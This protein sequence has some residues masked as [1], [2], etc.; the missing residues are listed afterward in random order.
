MEHGDTDFDLRPGRI[1]TV[2]AATLKRVRAVVRI[3]SGRNRKSAATARIAPRSGIRAHVFKGA[4]QRGGPARPVI[5]GQRR[6]VVKARFLAHGASKLAPL[7]AHLAYLA[8]EARAPIVE[9]AEGEHARSIDHLSR[10]AYDGASRYEF[11]DQNAV[12]IDAKTAILRWSEDAR[13]FRM[14]V[15]AEEGDALG[16]LKP[17]IREVMAHLEMKLG[18]PL[19]WLA[20]DHHDTDN[21]HTHV[22][23]RGRRADGQDLFIPSRLI[24]SGIR[25][26]A[27]AVA[28]RVLG[29][30]LDADLARDRARDSAHPSVT[31]LDYE[32]AHSVG[33]ALRP[34]LVARLDR[35]EV[36]GLASR[37]ETG[38]RLSPTLI[39][40]LKAM[41][42][43]DE[44]ARAA[45]RARRGEPQASVLAAEPAAEILGELVYAGPVDDFGERFVAILETGS[46]ELRY[47]RMTR[48]EDLMTL[49][50]APLGAIAKLE[51]VKPSAR[52]SDEA[53]ARIAADAGGVYRVEDHLRREPGVPR[54]L[55][56]ANIRRLEALRRAGLV[57]R[58]SDGAF[59]IAPNHLERALAFEAQAARQAPLAVR[60]A[61]YWTLEEQIDAAG[62]TL[63]DQ[64]LARE[65]AAPSGEGRFAKAHQ[66]ALEQRRLFLVEQGWMAPHE[67]MLDPRR[68]EAMADHEQK[69]LAADLSS[70]LKLPV[71][72]YSPAHLSGVYARRIDLAQGRV[73]LILTP[74]GGAL[75]PWRPALEPFAGKEVTATRR[76]QTLSWTLNRG[77]SLGIGL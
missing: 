10:E 64:V 57:E 56:E 8:R 26:H 13:H 48:S 53:V 58:R 19:E 11:Y 46:G 52:P 68:L 70:E 14:I 16:D 63:L 4:G 21:P 28:T 51:P 71:R 74:D 7:R 32:L 61:S 5:A 55:A 25:E 45:A 20:V 36:W 31:A 76:N 40:D 66:R 12:G 69:T 77:K 22:L 1:G 35:L 49:L 62:P 47:A 43:H 23:I 39:G 30:K 24:A 73:A 72:A 75:V 3:A 60:M 17:F 50:D 33:N 6:V 2:R 29:P 65:A 59:L 18:T 15:S 9:A 27:Q 37:E 41:A 42:D 34:E 54:G 38:W 67:Q 44:V